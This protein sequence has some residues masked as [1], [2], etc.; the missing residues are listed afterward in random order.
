MKNIK[1]SKV[2]P[3]QIF[4]FEGIAYKF[5]QTGN[6]KKLHFANGE[7]VK[8]PPVELLMPNTTVEVE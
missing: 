4:Y 6:W 7:P 3:E 8:M 5:I 2:K 1:I